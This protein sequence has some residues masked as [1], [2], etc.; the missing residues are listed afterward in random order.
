V[1]GDRILGRNLAEAIPAFHALPPNTILGTIPPPGAKRTLHALELTALAQRYSIALDAPEDIC[2]EYPMEALDR[3]RLMESLRES[4]QAPDARIEI[5]ESSLYPVPKGRLDF[6]R[7][8]LGKPSSAV[9]KDPVLWRGSVIYGG[10]HRFTVWAKVWIKAP[11]Q[12]NIAVEALKAGQSIDARQVRTETG[13]CFPAPEKSGHSP[14][15]SS[16]VGM[17]ALRAI[18]A[19]AEIKPELVAPP[20]DVNRGDSVHVEVR[21]GAAHIAFTAKAETSGRS[22]DLISLRNPSSNRT[23]RARVQGK[24][25]AVVQTESSG[26]DR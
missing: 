6:P 19:G 9:Q 21:S 10:D 25:Q 2:F 1:E 20:N 8:T 16:L 22:G 7:E 15:A 12:R 5:A 4:L 17:V 3:G 14:A 23:F 11:C 13:E 18:A 26:I 24:D